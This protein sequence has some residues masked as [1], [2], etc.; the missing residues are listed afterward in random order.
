LFLN[1]KLAAGLSPRTLQYLRAVLRQALGQALKWGLVARNV[2][3]LVDPP[4]VV[5]HEIQPLTPEQARAF[6]ESVQEHRLRALFAVAFAVGLRQGEALGLQ[7]AN[8]DL[9]K[10]LCTFVKRCNSLT[11]RSTSWN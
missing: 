1:A 2:A 8:V 7:W 6:L 10:R 4:R 9:D 5:R 3:M 11:V